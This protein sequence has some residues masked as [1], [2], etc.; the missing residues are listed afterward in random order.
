[1]RSQ[2]GLLPVGVVLALLLVLAGGCGGTDD[3]TDIGSPAVAGGLPHP[4]DHVQLDPA[5]KQ[6]CD[7][8]WSFGVF[9][10]TSHVKVNPPPDEHEKLHNGINESQPKATSLVPELAADFKALASHAH[11]AM[12]SKTA[13]PLTPDLTA[14]NQRLVAYLNN[15]CKFKQG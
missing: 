3:E 4:D 1:M 9:V 7:A 2:H 15:V 11:E 13:L 8:V 12:N 6:K 14:A 10:Y 5:T